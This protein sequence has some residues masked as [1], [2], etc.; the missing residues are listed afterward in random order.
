MG[1]VSTS[2]ELPQNSKRHAILGS[3]NCCPDLILTGHQYHVEFSL[4]MCLTEP[5]ISTVHLNIKTLDSRIYTFHVDKN[6][7]YYLISKLFLLVFFL[8]SYGL[9]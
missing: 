5:V 4:A 3:T 2:K 6:V 8:C 7:T 9:L 1:E